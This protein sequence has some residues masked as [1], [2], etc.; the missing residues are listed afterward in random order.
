MV[1]CRAIAGR[2]SVTSRWVPCSA[3]SNGLCIGAFFSIAFAGYAF[4]E[5]GSSTSG[6]VADVIFVHKTSCYFHAALNTSRQQ[7][8]YE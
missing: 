2:T 5:L 3:S 1:S 4:Y 6:R 7:L 8:F